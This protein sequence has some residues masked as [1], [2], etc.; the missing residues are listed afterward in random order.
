MRGDLD[1]IS[2][3]R[4]AGR[5]ILNRLSPWY[6]VKHRLLATAFCLAEHHKLVAAGR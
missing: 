2:L 5:G 1:R 6:G 3:S 4:V